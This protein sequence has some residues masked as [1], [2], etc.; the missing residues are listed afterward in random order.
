MPS[1]LTTIGASAFYK[2]TKLTSITI[3]ANVKSIGSKAFYGCKN[4]KKITIKTTKLTS[5]KVGSSVKS[6]AKFM[7]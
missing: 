4:L 3:P 6:T 5:K 2:C 7:V 1:K